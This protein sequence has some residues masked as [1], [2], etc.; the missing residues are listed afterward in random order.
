MVILNRIQPD[1]TTHVLIMGNKIGSVRP[2][3][4]QSP[5]EPVFGGP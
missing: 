4:V 5:A 3:Q 2:K 1:Y